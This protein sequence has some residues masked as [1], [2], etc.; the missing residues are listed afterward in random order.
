[1]KVSFKFRIESFSTFS[2]L[3]RFHLKI[4]EKHFE[5]KVKDS[6]KSVDHVTHGF[7]SCL[8]DFEVL[9]LLCSN[10]DPIV[11]LSWCGEEDTWERDWTADRKCE[12]DLLVS[13]LFHQFDTVLIFWLNASRFTPDLAVWRDQLW[14]PKIVL[15]RL[16]KLYFQVE[17]KLKT[18]F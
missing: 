10:F 2:S 6:I 1:M 9:H 14:T 16:P 12:L 11:L 17:L 13:L 18:T 7:P 15:G 8:R 4:S 5:S 3:K